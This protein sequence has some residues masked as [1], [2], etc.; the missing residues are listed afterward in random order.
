ME[1]LNGKSKDITA[2]NID[3]LKQL[4]PEAFTED[5]T[6][7]NAKRTKI[8]FEVLKELL[9]EYVT[10]REERY[11]FTWNGKS[12]ARMIAQT[13]STGTL[14]PCKEESVDWDTTQN[15]FIEGDNLEVLKLLQKSYH[16]K[17]KMIYIDPPYNTGKDFVYKDNFKDN[18]K[19]Y[20]EI[21]GQVDG[22]GRNLSNN[23]ETS[24]R[25]HTDWLNMMY[26]RLKLARNLLKDDGVIFISIDDN[27]VSNLRKMCDEVFGE[28]N[29]ACTFLIKSNPRG[30]QSTVFCASVHEHVLC[31]VKNSVL[32]CG[33]TQPLSEEMVAE[34]K[35][36]D[37][38]GKYRLL[39]LRLRGGSWRREQRPLLYYPIYVNPEDESISLEKSNDFFIEVLPIKPST[40][41]EGTWRWSKQ[42]FVHS[43]EQ[44]IPKQV[45]RDSETVW[46][47]FQ[48]DYLNSSEGEQKGTKPKT[49]WDE[50]EM[51]YQNGTVSVRELFDNNPFDF[52]K[53]VEMLKRLIELSSNQNDIVLDFFAGSST[54]AHALLRLNLK[55]K[56]NRKFIMIQLPELC[57]EKSE[58]FKA[59]YKTIAEISKE[60]IR[61]AAAKIKEENPEYNGDLGFKV[62]KLDSTN[63]KLWEVDFDMTERTLEDFISNI[64]T[65]RR[66]EDVLYEILLKY[67]LDL[68]LPI[69]EHV[70]AGQKVFDIGMGALIICLADAI[71]LEVV[72]GIAKLKDEL[73]PEIMRVVFKDSGFKDDVVK[74]NAVQILRTAGIVDV[75]SL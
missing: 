16:K 57:D 75:R 46:D 53:P 36:E 40:G 4:F 68:T 72:E 5:G 7:K 66:E 65:D 54:T 59:G 1:K 45:T 14:R 12:K 38:V 47:I 50:K 3:K 32:H 27:E 51:N 22:E 70:I 55:D 13:P 9:G 29:F 20:K 30:S 67:G 69:T 11:S 42:K 23:P 58:A 28:E 10:D 71:S 33:F 52:P 26:P 49:I 2:E 19:N 48:K 60:R 64:K 62:F 31:Y 25:Y 73:G 37:E 24:G 56:G 8:D 44:I 15:I 74:T 39:G 6:A 34:Y 21:T 61:R 63:I 43:Y 41:E 35:F 17:V 18:I